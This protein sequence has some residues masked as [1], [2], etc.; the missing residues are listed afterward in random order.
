MFGDW[1]I[2]VINS[3]V[4]WI[5]MKSGDEKNLKFANKRKSETL[6][7]MMFFGLFGLTKA[8][9][10]GGLLGTRLERAN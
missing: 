1:A 7:K 3:K 2:N 5:I 9:A 4:K 8:V 6:T 10:S